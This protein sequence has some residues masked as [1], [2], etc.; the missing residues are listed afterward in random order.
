M[1]LW[2]LVGSV[3]VDDGGEAFG[4]MHAGCN[5]I[6]LPDNSHAAKLQ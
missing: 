6:L 4:L 5:K 3:S 2:L 1:L